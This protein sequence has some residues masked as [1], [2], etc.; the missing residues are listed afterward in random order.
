MGLFGSRETIDLTD[1]GTVPV[2]QFVAERIPD[3]G[4]HFLNWLGCPGAEQASPY[5]DRLRGADG[6]IPLETLRPYGLRQY[7]KGP[8]TIMNWMLAYDRVLLEV[9]AS[10][11]RR[12]HGADKRAARDV[13]RRLVGEQGHASAAAWACAAR[14][15]AGLDVD[16][17]ASTLVSGWDEQLGK[18]QNRWVIKAFQKW[19]R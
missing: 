12:L 3:A 2:P 13:T 5:V 18:M 19:Q 4:A 10:G 16:W 1:P 17:L 6:W 8:L 9:F 14:P 7:D 15:Q 11:G